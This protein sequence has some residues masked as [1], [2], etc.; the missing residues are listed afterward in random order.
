MN[1]QPL[2]FSGYGAARPPLTLPSNPL[3]PPLPANVPVPTRTGWPTTLPAP[4]P[5]VS[6]GWSSKSRWIVF[7]I[8][9]VL[10]GVVVVVVLLFTGVFNEDE[11][12]VPLTTPVPLTSPVIPTV[13]IA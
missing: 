13:T 7:G 9:F 3:G 11:P 5:K 8:L 10:V 1:P 6:P 2:G 4:N 12:E